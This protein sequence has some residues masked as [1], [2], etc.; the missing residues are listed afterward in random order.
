MDDKKLHTPDGVRDI[1]PCEMAYKRAVENRIESVFAGF[2]YRPVASPAFEYADV[3]TQK[4][5]FD[6]EVPAAESQMIKFL[7]NH[8]HLLALRV[9]MTL[10]IARLVST[11]CADMPM[12]LRFSYVTDVFRQRENFQGKQKQVTQAGIELIGESSNF[13]AAE[14]IAAA[15]R[16][17]MAAG[18]DNFRVDISSVKFFRAA[19]S[20][21]GLNAKNA[22]M[23]Q[24]SILNKDYVSVEKI[25]AD[26]SAPA[27]NSRIKQLFSEMPLLSGKTD[28]LEYARNFVKSD[29]ALSALDRLEDICDILAC[30]GLEERVDCDLS[31]IGNLDY[32]NDIILKGYV[33]DTASY[34]I[35]GGQYDN[36]Y[37]CFG[38]PR[39]A[40][41]AAVDVDLLVSALKNKGV[42]YGE[43][44]SIVVAYS[45]SNAREALR[46]ADELR[47]SGEI[48]ETCFFGDDLE[49][50][51]RYAGGR[52]ILYYTAE[53]KGTI[54]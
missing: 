24:A 21:S 51:K 39:P 46:T 32:Y 31:L 5:T 20:E 53:K 18:L 29:E 16:S 41:G 43:R 19:L 28:T 8:G 4:G 12:P 13:A 33:Q 25:L 52:K 26:A 34:I 9:D 22:G 3:F 23:L 14:I 36:L 6:P 38:Q 49:A 50:L 40:V 2:G 15:A 35:N 27:G 54:L 37:A 17:V 10:A 48:V 30:Y 47:A 45:H 11:R 7:D 42:T 44:E 1:L